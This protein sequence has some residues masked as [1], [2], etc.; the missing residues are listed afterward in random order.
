MALTGEARAERLTRDI[1]AIAVGRTVV[2]LGVDLVELE[3]M[4]LALMRTPRLEE[5]CFSPAERE[6]AHRSR[7]ATPSLAARF[8]A[9]EAVMKALGVG[10]WA[11]RLRDV[12]VGRLP[13]GAPRLVVSGRAADLAA[14]RGVGSWGLSLTHTDT[15][16]LAVALAFAAGGH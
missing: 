16:A 5:R 12:E 11:F 14:S 2:G 4:R 13:G 15:T 1:G 8:A 3:R 10:L 6:Y 7:D 9:K